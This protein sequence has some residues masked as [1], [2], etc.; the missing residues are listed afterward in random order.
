M[1]TT[2]FRDWGKTNKFR[3][4]GTTPYRDQN[5]TVAVVNLQ[6]SHYG[7]RYYLNVALWLT[8]LG[9]ETSPKHLRCHLRTPLGELTG[10]DERDAFL[11]LRS[12]LTDSE[13]AARRRAVLDAA[14]S[15]H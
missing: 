12:D 4:N 11:D 8:A 2:V 15:P 14:G 3:R 10:I 6:G 7:G 9:A 5:E 1:P 13:R